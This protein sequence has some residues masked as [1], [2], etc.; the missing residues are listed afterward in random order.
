MPEILFR[1]RIPQKYENAI[2]LIG[3]AILLMV[4][5][6]VNVQDFINPIQLPK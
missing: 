4:L 5:I 2:N 6:Y 3:F 1:R